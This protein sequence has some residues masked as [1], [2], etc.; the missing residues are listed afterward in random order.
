MKLALQPALEMCFQ[1]VQNQNIFEG[2]KLSAYGLSV[3]CD[4][5]SEF[6]LK[7]AEELLQFVG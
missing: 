4:G 3:Y 7:K 6:Y 2:K 5:R 1:E